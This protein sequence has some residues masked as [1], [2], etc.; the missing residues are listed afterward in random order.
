MTNQV[1]K[2]PFIP[3]K[4]FQVA[5]QFDVFPKKNLIYRIVTYIFN[6]IFCPLQKIA[7][8]HIVT[9]P[10]G[11]SPQVLP[12]PIGWQDLDI[13]SADKVKLKGYLHLSHTTSNLPQEQKWV[14]FFLGNDTTAIRGICENDGLI[15]FAETANLN[16][17]TIDYR[18]VGE[19]QGWARSRHDLFKDGEAAVQYLLSLGIASEHILIYGHSLGG[20][21]ATHVAALHQEKDHEIRLLA[22][23]TFSSTSAVI[24]HALPM[25]HHDLPKVI[26]YFASFIFRFLGWE[27]NNT[28]IFQSL[29]GKKVATWC[30]GDPYIPEDINLA[31]ALPEKSSNILC[32]D[33]SRLVPRGSHLTSLFQEPSS[34]ELIRLVDSLFA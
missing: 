34:P 9:P 22:D 12:T 7:N 30:A 33:N 26:K 6:F 11:A 19:S 27:F 8:R 4:D 32:L 18:G 2:C 28:Q 31:R 17:L 1:Q 13:T 21:V 20:A 24:H 5:T 14:I 29:K 3:P 16:I 15:Q 23:R 10:G 25:I